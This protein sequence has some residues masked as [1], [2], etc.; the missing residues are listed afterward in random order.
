MLSV[1]PLAGKGT[2]IYLSRMNTLPIDPLLHDLCRALA[3]NPAVIL[4]APPGAGKSTRVPLAC[5][6]QPWLKGQKIL[7]LQPRRLAARHTAEYMARQR[8]EEIGQS[9]GYSV[10]FEKR[11]SERT[12]IEVVTEG[13]LT[14]RLQS[15]PELAGIG[16]VIFDEFHERSVHSDLALAL[17][18][19]VQSALRDDLK[20]L[21]MSATL[22]A[23]PLAALLG[24][25]PVLTSA[26]RSYPVETYYRPH[27]SEERIPERVVSGV[28][29][30]LR[31]CEGDILVF[32]P[33]AGEIHRCAELLASQTD[34][35][36]LP[37][38][39]G[40]PFARQQQAMI[41][42]DRRRVVLATNIAETS[43]TIEGVGVVVDSGWE[44]RPR[45]DSGSGLTRLE[46][47]RISAASAD[48]R[49]GRAGRL[50]PGSCYRLWSEGEQAQL[51]PQAPPEIRSVDLSALVLE[52]ACWG[53]FEPE[54]LTWMDPPSLSQCRQATLLLQDIQALDQ[55][56]RPTVLGRKMARLPLAPRLARMV[57]A[58]EELGETALACDLA[59]LLSE[60]DL[61]SR[62]KA[63]TVTTCD[64]L[65]RWQHLQRADSVPA[66]R[67]VKRAA[68]DLRRVMNCRDTSARPGDP[69]TVQRWLLPAWPDRVAQQRKPGSD[70]YLLSDG[71]GAVLSPRSGLK[72]P[73][74][75]LALRLEQRGGQTEIVIA[76]TIDRGLLE[77]LFDAQLQR[78][79]RVS[80]DEQEQRVVA[81]EV[82]ILRALTLSKRP[83][84][85]LP[86]EQ[87]EASLAGVRQ[88]GV[89]NLGWAKEA[90]QL[91]ARVGHCRS[92]QPDAGWP[93]L[94][95]DA[96]T[97]HLEEWL[98]PFLVG[99]A[100][101]A[102]LERFDPLE[103]LKTLIPWELQARLKVLLPE[104]IEVPSGSRPRVD[105]CA[106]GTP[107]LAVKLQELFGW[108]QGPRLC[109]GRL[110][111]MIHLLSPA[112]RPL[113]MTQDLEH[114][115]NAVYPE[116]RREMR[117][118]YPKHPWPE[119]PW[120]AQATA[121]TKKTMPR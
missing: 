36:V 112:G 25:C 4:Q 58:A 63:S 3:Q 62:A 66:A 35:A 107:V 13:I 1:F 18:R 47:K 22:D 113:A 76:S 109:D 44:R 115:W 50:G 101:R 5:L 37:L 100:S 121:K 70:R 55:N 80:W 54:R 19:D 98:A 45:F 111:I 7:M 28:K 119:D 118:R 6:D 52:L 42:G 59:A 89:E 103:A 39:G 72:R 97:E 26:G 78:C 77:D 53:E 17:C 75:L 56:G 95:S 108:K 116:V 68:A 86:E 64:L 11:R 21:I 23:D 40:M 105:Y 87:V 85:A 29:A 83:L 14:R 82:L 94:G 32:L 16:L 31:E 38:F 57:L 88:I 15:D 91:R 12:R 96:L 73:E 20:L 79:R 10:R 8:G 24:H 106:E 27:M 117:G 43:L 2:L 74:F 51:V 84:K 34:I 81:E 102:A 110:P 65:T 61:L 71:S 48:Q 104:R 114:F 49:R 67:A 9:V 69:L 41:S 33:G 93:D 120:N 60:R 90:R 92:C 30:A 99:I 46:L